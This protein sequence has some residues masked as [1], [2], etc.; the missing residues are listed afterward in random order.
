MDQPESGV[1]DKDF[2]VQVGNKLNVSQMYDL[3]TSEG[4]ILDRTLKNETNILK[5]PVPSGP[6]ETASVAL[7]PVW[8]SAE[9]GRY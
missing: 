7:C 2:E 9:Q 4:Q 3:Q 6:C 1:A 5:L 8:S